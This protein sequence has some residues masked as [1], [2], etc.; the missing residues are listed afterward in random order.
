MN[1]TAGVAVGSR[2]AVGVLVEACGVENVDVRMP[3]EASFGFRPEDGADGA[4]VFNTVGVI[5]GGLLPL[6]AAST[7]FPVI[8]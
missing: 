3:I 4:E 1:E 8:L 5:F 7:V 2:V 6:T